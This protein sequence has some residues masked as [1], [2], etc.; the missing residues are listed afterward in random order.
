MG[1]SLLCRARNKLYQNLTKFEG[2]MARSNQ[3]EQ[4]DEKLIL[5]ARRIER[6]AQ[7]HTQVHQMASRVTGEMAS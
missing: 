6:A 1:S 5:S 2:S 7:I 4:L 3:G